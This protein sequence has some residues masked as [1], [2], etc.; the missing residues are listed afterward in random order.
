MVVYDSLG[1]THEITMYFDKAASSS[2]YEFIVTCD[3]ADDLRAGAA[4]NAWSGLLSSGVIS[5]DSSGKIND[6]DMYDVDPSDGSLNA[7]AEATDLTNGYFTF[8]PTF[9]SLSMLIVLVVFRDNLEQLYLRKRIAVSRRK[10]APLGLGARTETPEIDT[11][12]DQL[13][14]GRVDP[15]ARVLSKE[16]ILG[17]YNDLIAEKREVNAAY[18]PPDLSSDEIEK[19][20]DRRIQARI[21]EEVDKL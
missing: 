3:P 18:H 6:I 16:S 4:G 20:V 8:S 15:N 11:I 14:A 13:F 12:L 5:F 10:L 2:S 19:L 9:M 17:A 21:E 1:S 7:M